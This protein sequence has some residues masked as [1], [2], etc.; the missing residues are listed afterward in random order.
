MIHNRLDDE[1]WLRHRYVDEG[2]S[3]ATIAAQLGCGRETVRRRLQRFGIER[4][5]ASEWVDDAGQV[6]RGPA[7]RDDQI[8]GGVPP[9][10]T[11]W[12]NTPKLTEE[13]VREI[14]EALRAGERPTDLA[15]R[16][17]VAK[18]TIS[19]IKSG[20]KWGWVE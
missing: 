6:R 20:D 16:Y 7:R 1:A 10:V 15:A 4:R 9:V 2:A 17:G 19:Q 5:E 8:G 18:T 14:K 13:K 11:R 3:I 12:N